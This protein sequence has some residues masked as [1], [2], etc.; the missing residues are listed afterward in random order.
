MTRA[1]LTEKILDVKRERG[2]TWKHICKAIDGFSPV[3]VAGAL[4]GQMK[5]NKP[6]AAKAAELFGLSKSEQ[7]TLSE[8][9]MRGAGVPMPPRGRRGSSHSSRGRAATT[10]GQMPP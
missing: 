6:Q 4:L 7:A 3:L 10:G 8:V 1:D 5:L 2:W 9:P